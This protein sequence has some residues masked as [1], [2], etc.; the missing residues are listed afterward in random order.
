MARVSKWDARWVNCW[1]TQRDLVPEEGYSAEKSVAILPWTFSRTF[2]LTEIVRSRGFVSRKL[3][4]L[5]DGDPSAL[6]SEYKREQLSKDRKVVRPKYG[7]SMRWDILAANLK[8]RPATN[9]LKRILLF[10]PSSRFS[11][12]HV[13]AFPLKIP[14]AASS[15][16]KHARVRVQ[17]CWRNPEL[18]A[19]RPRKADKGVENNLWRGGG[20]RGG[21]QPFSSRGVSITH[22][23]SSRNCCIVVVA[24]C[25]TTSWNFNEQ[26]RSGETFYTERINRLGFVPFY[27]VD[28][29]RTRKNCAK[30]DLQQNVKLVLK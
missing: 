25:F 21:G 26:F 9:E 6:I 29:C 13:A 17:Y 24:A 22:S 12:V 15:R 23:L 20:E 10:A 4:S 30:I 28:S 11:R 27:T 14:A 7:W 8:I 16:T 3:W 1:K 19:R 18:L 5:P 2:F